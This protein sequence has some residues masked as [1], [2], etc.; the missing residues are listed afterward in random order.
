MNKINF[1]T[2]HINRIDI[3]KLTDKKFLKGNPNFIKTSD[4]INFEQKEKSY[5]FTLST[6]N[7]IDIGKNE[8]CIE[9]T[10]VSKFIPHHFLTPPKI[11]EQMI[12]AHFFHTEAIISEQLVKEGFPEIFLHPEN[13][14]IE[15]RC[16]GLL[17]MQN[18]F[19][20]PESK[21]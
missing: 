3:I 21:P 1:D 5:I 4:M 12:Q 14:S 19:A 9:I 11:I 6:T 15:T 17:T 16:L 20:N 8:P 13:A 18:S 10:T 7:Y 2:V